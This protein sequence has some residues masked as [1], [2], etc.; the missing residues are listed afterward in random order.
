MLGVGKILTPICGLEKGGNELQMNGYEFV[1]MDDYESK[2]E[3][4]TMDL[5]PYCSYE[6]IAMMKKMGY[7]PGMGHG[8]EGRGVAEFLNFKTQLTKEGFDSLKAAKESKRNLV[9]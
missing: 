4:Y 5:L 7:M 3:K 6:V 8:K 9:P 2:D 1:N